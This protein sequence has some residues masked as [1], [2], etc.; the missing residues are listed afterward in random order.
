MMDIFSFPRTLGKTPAEQIAELVSYLIQFKETLE[1]TLMNISTDNL[2]PDLVK[3][4]NDMGANIEQSNE[5]R[6][7]EV[8]QLSNNTTLTIADVCN[9]QMFQNAVKG[10]VANV[11]YNVNFETGH[12][13]YNV[14]SKDG[15]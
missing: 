3:M 14:S 8:A 5:N 9:S 4:L 6:A 10:E 2:S 11:K 15:G 1:F 12:L 7:E 13:E